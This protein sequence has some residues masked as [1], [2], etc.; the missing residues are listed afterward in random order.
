M[1]AEERSVSRNSLR[2]PRRQGHSDELAG[3]EA[4][5][6]QP[7]RNL[8]GFPGR[9]PAAGFAWHGRRVILEPPK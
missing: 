7:W 8:S 6:L 2:M 4:I 5:R 9:P 3:D 1:G